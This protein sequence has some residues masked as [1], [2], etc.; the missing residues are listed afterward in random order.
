MSRRRSGAIVT[1]LSLLP[2]GKPLLQG[3]STA[4]ATGAVM[5]SNKAADAQSADDYVDKGIQKGERG[6]IQ[7]AIDDY[8]NAIEIKC[9]A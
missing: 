2:L 5:L 3:S 7:G 6:D 4:L 1:A 8:N 9:A